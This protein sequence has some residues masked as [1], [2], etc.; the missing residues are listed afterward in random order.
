MDTQILAPQL[1]QVSDIYVRFQINLHTY[2][3]LSMEYVQEV[4]IVPVR[5]ITP[6]P[7]MPECVM[8]LLNRRNRVLWVI[9]LAQLL[10]LQPVDTNVQQY[11][12]VVIRVGPVPLALVVQEA[13]GV[14]RF[15][16]NCIQSPVELDA[17]NITPY[18]NGYI[19]QEQETLLVMNAEAIVN[20]PILHNY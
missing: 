19:L 12:M 8:G 6:M 4:I 5:R 15:M 18:I 16:P 7:N 9:D 17:L 20:S 1:N 10:N 11:H 13:K 3:V 2:A 14:T